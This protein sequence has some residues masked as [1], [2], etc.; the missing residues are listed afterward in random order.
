MEMLQTNAKWLAEIREKARKDFESFPLPQER[1]EAWR[2]TNLKGMNI[3][4]KPG[5]ASSVMIECDNDRAIAVDFATAVQ[6]YPDMVKKH[7]GRLVQSSDK[8]SAFH[9]A[10]FSDGVFI[11]VPKE[12]RA[13]V[14]V[15]F[16]TANAHNIIVTEEGAELDYSEHFIG[17]TDTTPTDVTEI[18]AHEN[19]AVSFSSLQ[20]FGRNTNAFS[21]K[22]AQA[23]RNASVKWTFL[24]AGGKFYRLRA[25]TE[26]A[27]E[28]ANAETI[29]AS[30][31]RES[32]HMDITTNAHHKA[33]HTA[34]N[35]LAKSV[36]LGD[37]TAVYRGHIKI[38]PA[39]QQTNSYLSDHM[40]MA[41]DKALANSIP[42]L[43]IQANDVKASHGSTTGQIDEEQLFYL[44][45]RGLPREEA[46]RLIIQGFL[47]PVLARITNAEMRQSFA[48][49]I[50]VEE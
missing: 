25:S 49:T 36:L 27:G 12:E 31:S 3:D 1:E 4:F 23:G 20:G 39:A 18:F 2:Y 15:V 10:N 7:F 50:G 17:D 37:S 5:D 24:S 11:C 26:F 9:F 43:D 38:D 47:L 46:E 45:S 28:G 19:S 44:E 21:I 48:R 42:S 41:G 34:N 35:I 40:L 6:K 32:Q 30:L 33:P 22:N 16:E 29:C 14:S 13:A 8:I